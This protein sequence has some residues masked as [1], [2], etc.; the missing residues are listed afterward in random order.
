MGS[1]FMLFFV[2]FL[3]PQVTQDAWISSK[4]SWYIPIPL[5]TRYLELKEDFADNQ[6]ESLA[7]CI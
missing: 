5:Y 3:F 1:P 7:Y 4:E 2:L 6:E